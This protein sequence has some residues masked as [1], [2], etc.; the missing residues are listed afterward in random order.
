M[1]ETARITGIYVAPGELPSA[2]GPQGNSFLLTSEFARSFPEVI[3]PTAARCCCDSALALRDEVRSA[4]DSFGL[5][6]DVNESADLTSRIE[7]TIRV[8]TVALLIL[9]VVVAGVGLVLVGQML[10][11]Q[12]VA[13]DDQALAFSALGCDR[14]GALGSDC[15]AASRWWTG[16]SWAGQSRSGC[17][18][19]SP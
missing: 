19:C 13:E 9:G 12:S 1:L 2:S 16:R 11:R 8:E 6:L 7:R 3:E 15:S 18:R 14:V 5:G 10:R 4:I 17:R